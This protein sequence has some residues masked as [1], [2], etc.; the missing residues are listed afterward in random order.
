[1]AYAR[2]E[3]EKSINEDK[4]DAFI[5]VREAWGHKIRDYLKL[6]KGD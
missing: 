5:E 6:D 4:R 2:A 3:D 1:M